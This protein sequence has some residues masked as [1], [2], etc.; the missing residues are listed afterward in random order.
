M[1]ALLAAP[2]LAIKALL[3]VTS[4]ILIRA[5][6]PRYRYDQLMLLG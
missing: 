1:S 3:L 4:M 2:I 6:Y 5:A